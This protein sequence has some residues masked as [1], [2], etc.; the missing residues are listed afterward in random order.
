MNYFG[1]R[2]VPQC[3]LTQRLMLIG[4]AGCILLFCSMASAIEAE[5]M[6]PENPSVPEESRPGPIGL[7]VS[8][9]SAGITTEYFEQ[10]VTDA[11][12]T[13]KIFSGVDASGSSDVVM[14]MLRVDGHFPSTDFSTN[15]PYFLNIRVTKV[16]T[17]SFSIWMTVSMNAIWTLYRSADKTE[18]MHENINS[19]YTGGMFEGGIAGANRVRVAM[20]GASRESI[21][22]GM[23][24]LESLDFEQFEAQAEELAA[25]T[26]AP[27]E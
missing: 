15:T 27:M 10:A 4:I 22:I 8:G 1:D 13:S 9:A 3:I 25:G 5:T 6:T 12:I 16:E 19:T 20:E 2:Y 24:M 21:R 7:A 17:P 26:P 11:L 18:L 14:H 23:G